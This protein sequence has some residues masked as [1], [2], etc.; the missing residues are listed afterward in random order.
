VEVA[1]GAGLVGLAICKDMDFPGLSRSYAQAG[2]GLLAVPAWDFT[3]DAWLHSRI[4]L[5][6]GVATGLSIARTARDG[7]L[8]VSDPEGRVVA[9]AR[10]GTAAVTSVQASIPF[11][12][13]QTLYDA[14]A[15]WFAWLCLLVTVA[16]LA[17]GRRWGSRRTS[18]RQHSLV[19]SPSKE[20]LGSPVVRGA[21]I[22][23]DDFASQVKVDQLAGVDRAAS[24]SVDEVG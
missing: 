21:A 2:A 15:D 24:E 9:E 23:D 1:D 17:G 4:A 8:T 5:T 11:G 10:T 13:H 6:A 3:V 12:T 18:P 22:R 14:L 20:G 19:S 16:G 7:A